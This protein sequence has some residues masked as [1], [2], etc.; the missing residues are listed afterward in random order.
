MTFNTFTQR[1]NLADINTFEGVIKLMT[2]NA[3]AQ[4]SNLK[5]TN[6]LCFSI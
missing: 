1:S 2:F 5:D 6:T 3:F 4:C